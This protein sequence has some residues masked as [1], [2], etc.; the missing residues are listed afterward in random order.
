MEIKNPKYVKDRE[1]VER[2]IICERDGH[3]VN[4]PMDELNT[5][6]KYILKQVADGNLTIAAAD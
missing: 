3:V 5:V 2:T 6:Y 1:G 4:V